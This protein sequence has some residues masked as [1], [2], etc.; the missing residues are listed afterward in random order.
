[1]CLFLS[2]RAK[3]VITGCALAD[4]F[5]ATWRDSTYPSIAFMVSVGG[6]GACQITNFY[7]FL[8]HISNVAEIEKKVQYSRMPE[9]SVNSWITVHMR[10]LYVHCR[11]RGIQSVRPR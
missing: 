3:S 11:L 6:G 7:G 1:M 9:K 10:L 5:G 4:K 8:M 2:K